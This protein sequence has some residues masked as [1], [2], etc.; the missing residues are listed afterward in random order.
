MTIDIAGI[1]RSALGQADRLVPLWLPNGQARSNE[2]VAA[3]P[4]RPTSD[5]SGAFSINLHTGR[6]GDFAG[7]ACDRGGDLVSLY[8]YLHDVNQG[9]AA[10]AVAELIGFALDDGRPAAARQPTPLPL[11]RALAPVDDQFDLVSPAPADAPD[12][13]P[14]L[15]HPSL[16]RAQG[17]WVYRNAAGAILFIVV[18]FADPQKAGA[19]EIRPYTL[20]RQT[21]GALAWKPKGLPPLRPLYRMDLIAKHPDATVVVCEGEKAADAAQ[22]LMRAPEYVATTSPNGSKNASKADWTAL[23]GRRCLIWP[24]HDEPGIGYASDVRRELQTAEVGSVQVIAY[25]WIEQVQVVA[26]EMRRTACGAGEGTR[27]A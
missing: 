1:A 7:G 6:W 22:R 5:G 21:S 3:N 13:A 26:A 17:H 12:F 11:P 8:A 18:R 4:K 14:I 10:R 27:V 9:Q 19:K 23:A 20:R 25:E 16:G 24:D 15:N 2:W